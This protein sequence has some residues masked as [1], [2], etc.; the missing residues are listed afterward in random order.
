[1]ILPVRDSILLNPTSRAR[2]EGLL[3]L[4]R[5]KEHV[6]FTVPATLLGVNM[7]VRSHSGPLVPDWRVPVILAADILAVT[8]AFMV[9]DIEDA[10]DD[11]RDVE[12][13]ARNAV[14][15]AAISRRDGWRASAVVGGVALA[16]FAWVGWA[17]LAVGALTVSLGFLYSWR[18]VRLKAVPV[19]DVLAHLLMLSVLLFVAG[20][21]TYD[22]LPGNII[23]LVAASAG[24][25]SAYG[26]VYNQLRDYEMDRAAG[27]RNTASVLGR[28]R[29]QWLMHAC[30][31]GSG[32]GFAATVLIGLWPQWL[33]PATLVMSP[34]VLVFRRG[35]DMRG[36]WAADA[37]GRLQVGA[38][39]AANVVVV[40]WL[41]ENWIK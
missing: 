13:G 21:V 24:L 6:P 23:W 36:T 26:Q 25:L 19:L 18:G 35:T 10:P 32:I 5:W 11:A 39:A 1:M 22:H 8:F 28:Q 41:F 29:A 16:L 2:A 7:A 3:R 30:L 14:V 38:M 20:Y 33:I 17:A 31:A 12:R 27:L 9:N 40:L 37:S 4:S 34:L 15:S